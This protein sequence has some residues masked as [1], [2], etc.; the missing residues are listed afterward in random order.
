M[1]VFFDANLKILRIL[2]SYSLS[3][4]IL[5][6]TCIGARMYYFISQPSDDQVVGLDYLEIKP[7]QPKL[8]LQLRQFGYFWG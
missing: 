6:L 1:Q 5:L 2:W 7:S 3:R 8:E 4:T